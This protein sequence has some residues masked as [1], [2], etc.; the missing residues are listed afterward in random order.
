MRWL[1]SWTLY[2]MG[3]LVWRIFYVWTGIGMGSWPVYQ[4]YNRLMLWSDSV[5]GDGRGPWGP[6]MQ[7][8]E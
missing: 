7:G 4:T 1:A 3:D 8:V 6:R 2:L 5:Q